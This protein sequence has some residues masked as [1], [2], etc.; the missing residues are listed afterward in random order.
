MEAIGG[1]EHQKSD[2]LPDSLAFSLPISTIVEQRKEISQAIDSL[3]PAGLPRALG[4]RFIL[5]CANITGAKGDGPSQLGIF[6]DLLLLNLC[7]N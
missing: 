5:L 2:T 6:S 4:H 3:T 7:E 1:T